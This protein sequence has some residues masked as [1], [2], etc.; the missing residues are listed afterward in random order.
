MFF[1][2][3][4]GA[5]TYQIFNWIIGKTSFRQCYVNCCTRTNF[6]LQTDLTVVDLNCMFYDRQTQPGAPGCF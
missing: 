1:G 6:T 5:N 2:K 3:E 4:Q